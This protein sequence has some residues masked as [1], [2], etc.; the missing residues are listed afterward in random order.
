MLIAWLL[1]ADPHPRKHRGG[2]G[3]L[4]PGR[5]DAVKPSSSLLIPFPAA[6]P[7]R[8][9]QAV[10]GAGQRFAD[11]VFFSIGKYQF[12]WEHLNFDQIFLFLGWSEEYLK[13]RPFEEVR[14]PPDLDWRRAQQ[15]GCGA[16]RV[17]K[18]K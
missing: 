2:A 15:G 16:Q 17:M 1:T 9:D 3:S 10:T 4:P 18:W 14:L 6:L 5:R 11:G 12:L 8:H 7:H 13:A